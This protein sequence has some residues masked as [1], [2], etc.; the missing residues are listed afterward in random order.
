M[1]QL[2]SMT[3]HKGTSWYLRCP[4]HAKVMKIFEINR[5]RIVSIEII[6]PYPIPR[7]AEDSSGV[8]QARQITA[9]QSPHVN[10]SV[11]SRAQLGQYS[12]SAGLGGKSSGCVIGL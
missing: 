9:E 6:C 3:F 12:A 5:R 4:Y 1:P 8:P 11:T 2:A 10:G 7:S